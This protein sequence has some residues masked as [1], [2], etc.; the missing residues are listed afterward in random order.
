M[1]DTGI[2][3]GDLYD[4]WRVANINMPQVQAV[5]ADA[6]NVIHKVNMPDEEKLG[7]AHPAWAALGQIYEQCLWLTEGSLYSVASRIDQA[8]EEFKEVDENA[9]RE[10]D[11]TF[12]DPDKHD[13]D[14]E[15]TDDEKPAG[16]EVPNWWNDNDE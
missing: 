6:C 15:L 13:P 7:R 16:T 5:Y 2:T 9:A 1:N 8:V 3:G 14:E 12:D 11:A 10:L 4:L